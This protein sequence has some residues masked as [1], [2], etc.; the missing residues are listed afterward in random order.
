LSSTDK[1]INKKHQLWQAGDDGGGAG[2]GHNA[3]KAWEAEEAE[4][5]W[6]VELAGI[7]ALS[8]RGSGRG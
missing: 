3:N 7:T 4:I 8:S 1:V 5:D 6:Q 2:G